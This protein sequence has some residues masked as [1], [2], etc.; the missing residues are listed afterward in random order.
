M[1]PNDIPSLG[2]SIFANFFL[3]INRRNIGLDNDS[4]CEVRKYMLTFTGEFFALFKYCQSLKVMQESH[5]DEIYQ[6]YPSIYNPDLDKSTTTKSS[7]ARTPSPTHDK[8]YDI[9]NEKDDT[10]QAPNRQIAM[11]SPSHN[12]VTS[13]EKYDEPLHERYEEDLEIKKPP[14]SDTKAGSF[15]DKSEPYVFISLLL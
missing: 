6:Q 5:I 2:L 13:F 12:Q 15:E 4:V 14:E 1:S 7:T 9:S 11:S 3:Q 8:S 10:G